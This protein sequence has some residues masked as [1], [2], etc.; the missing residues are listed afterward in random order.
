MPQGQL[1][2]AIARDNLPAQVRS[3]IHVGAHR[4]EEARLYDSMGWAPVW[5]IEMHPGLIA[6]LDRLVG[7]KRG[8]HVIHA[9]VGGPQEAGQRRRIHQAS[10]SY[11]SSLLEPK[12]H[13][14]EHPKV[15]FSRGPEV[16]TTT[17]DALAQL[18]HWPASG[19]LLV[20]DIQGM[21]LAALEGGRDVLPSCC[22]VYCEVNTAELYAGCGLLEQI[23]A[24]L[25]E[26]GFKRTLLKM[27][28]HG[29][30]DAIYCRKTDNAPAN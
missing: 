25:S 7:R 10:N 17:L 8:H 24:L 16:T 11:S 30:G 2:A 4:G 27:T 18:H 1:S 3:V 23:D 9:A 15:K 6:T 28:S 20:L 14:T 5:W 12:L 13:K 21:E 26:A 22:A 19:N 29:W